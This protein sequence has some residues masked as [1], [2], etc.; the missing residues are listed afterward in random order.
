MDRVLMSVKTKVRTRSWPKAGPYHPL[1]ATPYI[2][3]N[4]G[5]KYCLPRCEQ[6][7]HMIVVSHE[8]ACHMIVVSHRLLDS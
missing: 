8:Q 3:A 2:G 6:A 7:C 5:V 1:L 4:Q